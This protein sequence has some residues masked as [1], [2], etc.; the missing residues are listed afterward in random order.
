[1]ING[2]TAYLNER[3]LKMIKSWQDGQKVI[4]FSNFDAHE[5]RADRD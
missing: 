4:I 2:R 5:Q 1:M 3:V